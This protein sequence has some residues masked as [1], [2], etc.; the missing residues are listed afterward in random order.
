[1]KKVSERTGKKGN[2]NR[3]IKRERTGKKGNQ[4]RV[5]K[6][7]WKVE[8]RTIDR[9]KQRAE[10]KEGSSRGEEEKGRE[11]RMFIRQK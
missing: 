3:V 5:I 7:E 11:I 4:K 2:Q 9:G 8:K 10:E 1:M 6:R